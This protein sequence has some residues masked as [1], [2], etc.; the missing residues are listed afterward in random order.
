M[1][2]LIDWMKGKIET[3][4]EMKMKV[5]Y[6]FNS[7]NHWLDY[8]EELEIQSWM[9]ELEIERIRNL[10]LGHHPWASLIRAWW[11][12]WKIRTCG[13]PII[14][15][16]KERK[17][18]NERKVD[19]CR[20]QEIDDWLMR[21]EIDL[22]IEKKEL[23]ELDKRQEWRIQKVEKK[24]RR[25]TCR[26]H[27]IVNERNLMDGKCWPSLSWKRRW[28]HLWLKPGRMERQEYGTFPSVLFL[29]SFSFS[30]LFVLQIMEIGYKIITYMI[31]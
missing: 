25:K 27:I 18:K 2:S 29:D 3:K 12:R 15:Q 10:T 16:R 23:D 13:K 9:N 28:R 11:I 31:D 6:K 7:F 26:C 19:L 22:E 8:L 24:Q 1:W 20:G 14:D 17:D 5:D 4:K 30:F 21:Q